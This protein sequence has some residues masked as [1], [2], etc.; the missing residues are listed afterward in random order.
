MGDEGPTNGDR[1]GDRK[2]N[3]EREGIPGNTATPESRSRS[4]SVC[5]REGGEVSDVRG[6][7]AA[8][9]GARGNRGED[10]G[11]DGAVTL[12]VKFGRG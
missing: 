1:A 3:G 12:T 2:Q 10:E 11:K 9:Y 6:K 5:G 4:T 7:E 8:R